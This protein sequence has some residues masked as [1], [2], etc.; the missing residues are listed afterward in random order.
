MKNLK[1]KK[2]SGCDE[3]NNR[4]IKMISNEAVLYL[5]IIFDDCL[6]LG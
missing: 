1:N 2:S 6:K 3:I 4:E 5:K